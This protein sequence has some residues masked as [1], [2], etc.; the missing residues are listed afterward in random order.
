M[1][2]DDTACRGS[3]IIH[4]GQSRVVVSPCQQTRSKKP[5]GIAYVLVPGFKTCRMQ[6]EG[7]AITYTIDYGSVALGEEVDSF[8]PGVVHVLPDYIK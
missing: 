3:L 7:E 6:I 5:G 8:F 1:K 2:L 4:K